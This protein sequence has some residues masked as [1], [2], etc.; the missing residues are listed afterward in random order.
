MSVTTE[1]MGFAEAMKAGLFGPRPQA[2]DIQTG[3]RVITDDGVLGIVAE[4][5][6]SHAEIVDSAGR[7]HTYNLGQVETH[8]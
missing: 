2:D 8:R 4:L 1:T 7:W 5:S 3:D 6:R